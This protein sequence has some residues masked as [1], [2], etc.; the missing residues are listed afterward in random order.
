M[1]L[2]R[3]RKS[4]GGNILDEE[5]KAQPV[6]E[7]VEK[8]VEQPIDLPAAQPEPA[9]LVYIGPSLPGGLLNQYATFSGGFPHY[10]KPLI[11][12]CA[13][14]KRL[15]V[16]PALTTRARIEMQQQGSTYAADLAA[17]KKHFFKGAR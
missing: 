16:A 7:P 1:A 15:F 4:Q 3:S 2:K 13:E 17:V 8:E 6:G 5:K 10:I 9:K 12:Q 14:L 11:E